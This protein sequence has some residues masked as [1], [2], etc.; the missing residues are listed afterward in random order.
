MNDRDQRRYDRAVRV[1]TFGRENAA[2]FASGSKAQ[3]L[4]AETDVLIGKADRAKAGQSP[5]RVSKETLLDSLLL[6]EKNIA[7]T[8]RAIELKENGFAAPF[9]VPDDLSE[10]VI[11]TQADALLARLEDDGED[12]ADVKTAKAALRARFVDY[13]LPADFVANLRAD[14]DAI[15]DANRLNQGQTQGGVGNTRLLG[16]LLGR[17]NEVVMELDAIMFNK[18]TRQ[19]EKLRAW[20]SASHVERAAQREKKEAAPATPVPAA[21]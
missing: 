16:E 7:R 20:Q 15:T 14:R 5:N 18:Y 1:Q 10:T 8:A 2:D 21:A 4:F 11:T 19:P 6:D 9:R 12:S 17:I 13:E 3:T